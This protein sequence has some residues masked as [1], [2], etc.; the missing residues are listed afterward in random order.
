MKFLFTLSLILTFQLANSQTIDPFSKALEIQGLASNSEKVEYKANHSSIFDYIP[1]F[2]SKASEED[3]AKIFSAPNF[4]RFSVTGFGIIYERKGG[5]EISKEEISEI[6]KQ[7]FSYREMFNK[8][9][10]EKS[11][12]MVNNYFDFEEKSI[13]WPSGLVVVFR[14]KQ[15]TH[16]WMDF[17]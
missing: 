15:L 14:N 17:K 3:L 16:V 4:E 6:A 9:K 5:K 8:I 11:D 7:I 12:V 10:K 13:L 2:F 1:D